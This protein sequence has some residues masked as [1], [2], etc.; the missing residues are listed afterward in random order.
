MPRKLKTHCKQGHEYTEE[1]TYVT[2]RGWRQCRACKRRNNDKWLSAARDDMN[3]RRR[4]RYLSD[5]AY[6]QGTLDRNRDWAS[7]NPDKVNEISRVK[8]HRRRAAGELSVS[9]WQEVLEQH[10]TVCL[11]CGDAGR[12]VTIDHIVPVSKGGT[13]SKDNL[14]PLCGPC[15][16]SKADKTLDYRSINA[17]R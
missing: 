14:Q 11:A 2:S 1:N 15:N 7:R 8:K 6:R 10:G 3:E 12:E 13:N 4:E 16:S 5:E 9:D 17:A